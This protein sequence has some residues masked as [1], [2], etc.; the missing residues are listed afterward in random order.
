MADVAVR[1]GSRLGVGLGGDYVSAQNTSQFGFMEGINYHTVNSIPMLRAYV[2]RPGLYYTLP[3]GRLL[4]LKLCGGPAIYFSE[5]EYNRNAVALKFEE[6]FHQRARNTF[7][8]VQAGAGLEVHLNERAALV[9][10]ATGRYARTSNLE[11]EEKHVRIYE[12]LDV[13]PPDYEGPLY[14]IPDAAFPRL[15]VRPEAPSAGARKAIF[16]FSG[17]DLTLGLRVKF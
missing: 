15:S 8:G 5:F 6:N 2:L 10:Q 7:V 13:S 14:F 17:V 9:F 1:V 11:G 3:L 12:T 16:D 4:S